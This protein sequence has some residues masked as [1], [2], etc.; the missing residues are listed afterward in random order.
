LGKG[1]F[2]RKMINLGPAFQGYT[3][4]SAREILPEDIIL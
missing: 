3:Y 4:H 1:L 2:E